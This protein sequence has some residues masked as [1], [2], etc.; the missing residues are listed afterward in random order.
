[1]NS[2][3]WFAALP[4]AQ[5]VPGFAAW[6]AKVD[7]II[8]AKFGVGADDL[9]DFLYLDEFEDGATP[10]Q[11]AFAAIKAAKEDF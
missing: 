7:A 10:K 3:D 6:M 8:A 2:K 1:M 4:E 11:A 9:P 5:P